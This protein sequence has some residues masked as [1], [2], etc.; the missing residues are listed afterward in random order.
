MAYRRK[1]MGQTDWSS[2]WCSTGLLS[3]SSSTCA[4]LVSAANPI[5]NIPTPPAGAAPGA[6]T[7]TQLQANLP[8]GSDV[9]GTQFSPTQSAVY[10]AQSYQQ[11]VQEF[12]NSLAGQPDFQSSGGGGG[13]V[14]WYCQYLGIGCGDGQSSNGVPGW[15]WAVG[16]TLAGVVVLD[17]F[18]GHR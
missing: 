4:S 6:P 17:A 3:P 1:G 5:G 14:P 2:F 11:Q 15:A 13:S 7:A 8:G 18:V 12:F 10:S 16:L 9:T